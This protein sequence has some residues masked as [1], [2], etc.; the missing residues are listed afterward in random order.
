MVESEQKLV[1]G[2]FAVLPQAMKEVT[3]MGAQA[4]GDQ[5]LPNACYT[6]W[7]DQPELEIDQGDNVF[8]VH[9]D[10]YIDE[11]GYRMFSTYQK[12]LNDTLT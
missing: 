7:R 10:Q 4:I 3:A 8:Q 12:F 6:H 5:D 9:L 2:I 11:H 1:D